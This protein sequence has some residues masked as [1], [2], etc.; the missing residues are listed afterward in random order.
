MGK[1]LFAQ[2]IHNV[3]RHKSAPLVAI[4]CVALP[5]SVLESEP[6]GYVK[7]AFTG[8]WSEGKARMLELAY[9]GTIFL[10]EISKTPPDVQLKLLRVTQK[11]KVIRLGDDRVI[12]VDVHITAASS[13]SL[14]EPVQND[15]FREDF[16]CR[17][18]ALKPQLPVLD[19]YR[20]DILDL[21]CCFLENPGLPSEKITE[22]ALNPLMKQ[23]RRGNTRQL[24]NIVERLAVVYDIDTITADLV[25]HTV[26]VEP[27]A[28]TEGVLP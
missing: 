17:T 11:R 21:V 7:G 3:S 26:L 18:C 24:N 16:C 15:L 9:N 10:D 4:N 27:R 13:R 14:R 28:W 23:Q 22:E 5:T 8:A 6:F 12:F 20:E 2:S 19:E 25:E 1:K